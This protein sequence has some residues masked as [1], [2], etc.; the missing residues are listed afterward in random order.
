MSVWALAAS[1]VLNV[2]LA[3]L[4]W[5]T[6]KRIPK[7]LQPLTS[8]NQGERRFCVSP[9]LNVYRDGSWRVVNEADLQIA[10]AGCEAHYTAV[11]QTGDGK[12]F[13]LFKIE[14]M[15]VVQVT[16]TEK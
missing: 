13:I 15:P 5:R 10:F 2:A 4:G 7:K 11:G 6:A 12:G 14:G 3:W 16:D 9:T 8:E 1:L